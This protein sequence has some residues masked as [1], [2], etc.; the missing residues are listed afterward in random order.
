MLSLTD[1]VHR[2]AS[3]F[4]VDQE[5]L[6]HGVEALFIVITDI[7]ILETNIYIAEIRI[8]E[9]NISIA[10]IRILETNI[11]IA[12]IRILETNICIAGKHKH[13]PTTKEGRTITI[14]ETVIGVNGNV[15]LLYTSRCV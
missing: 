8:L 1:W 6:D 12:E 2:Q 7:R 5:R 15:C 3:L 13:V 10:E 9:R 14:T 11:S 4:V